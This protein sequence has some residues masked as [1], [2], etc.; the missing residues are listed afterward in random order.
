MGCAIQRGYFD[1]AAK[2]GGGEAYRHFAVQ[3][4][5]FTLEDGV[6]LEMNL[7]VQVTRGAAVYTGFAF[8]C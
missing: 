6:R 7:Y 3:V 5:M 1:F 8:A 4:V 2:C